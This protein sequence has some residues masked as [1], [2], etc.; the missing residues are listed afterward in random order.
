MTR[1]LEKDDTTIEFETKKSKTD[2]EIFGSNKFYFSFFTA[3]L[4]ET[5]KMFI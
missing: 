2:K 3:K 4:V 1:Q 5:H